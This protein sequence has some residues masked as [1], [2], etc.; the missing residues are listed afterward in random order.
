MG[1]V[2]TD[3]WYAYITRLIAICLL[4]TLLVLILVVLI[5]AKEDARVKQVAGIFVIL[6][7]SYIT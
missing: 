6:L 4:F 1:T 2:V 3:H 7:T 5:F